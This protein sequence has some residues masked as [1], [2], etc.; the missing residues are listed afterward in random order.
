MR[1]FLVT[2]TTFEWANI[3]AFCLSLLGLGLALSQGL[4]ENDKA[5]T[6]WT[7][8]A[9][10]CA[11]GFL[12]LVLV[13]RP[14]VQI[15]GYNQTMKLLEKIVDASRYEI[16]TVRSHTGSG[17]REL[18]YFEGIRNRLSDKKSPLGNVR[19]LMRLGS[20]SARHLEWLI[21]NVAKFDGMEVFGF[22]GPGP[23]IDLMVSD[24]RIAVIGFP[25]PKASGNSV[26]ILVRR[27]D[28]IRGVESVISA[29][30]DE[31][32][33]LFRGDAGTPIDQT[34]GSV[35]ALLA[36]HSIDIAIG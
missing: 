33:L 12:L 31:S 30:Q 6:V 8:A 20:S 21:E 11:F 14:S 1:Y 23:Q 15:R 7:V 26:A 18:P 13:L 3:S 29:L 9:L 34:K 32:I 10:C 16:A 36:E 22:A 27:R 2:L 5:A 35:Q 28:S 19:R 24:G 17:D 4:A 25:P